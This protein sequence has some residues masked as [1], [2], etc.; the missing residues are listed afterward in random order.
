MCLH[1]EATL[2]SLKKVPSFNNGHCCIEV[3]VLITF[4][5]HSHFPRCWCSSLC[6]FFCICGSK[7]DAGT[8]VPTSGSKFLPPATKL[9]QGN[10]FTPVC[11]SVHTHAPLPH[12]PPTTHPPAMHALL[13]CMPPC[14]T[15]PLPC[16]PS[17]HACPPAMYP[18]AM[19]VLLP[20][21]PPLRHEVNERAVRI[22]LECILVSIS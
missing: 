3:P 6:I 12:M 4:F 8:R 16:M 2:N 17:C 10:V 19:H 1:S 15:R 20:C 11:H 22:L 21:I 14:H 18:P 13:P 9:R 7:G 5:H